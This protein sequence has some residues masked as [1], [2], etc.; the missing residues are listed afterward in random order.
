MLA[1]VTM[2]MCAAQPLLAGELPPLPADPQIAA[3]LKEISPARIR[4]DIDKL[5]SF[6]TRSTLS[7]QDPAAIAAGRGIGA[8]REWLKSQFELYA[9]ACHGCLEV[10]TD[11][12]TQMPEGR[13]P[14]PTVITNVYAV[15]KGTDPLGAAHRPG[16][17]P[18]RFARHRCPGCQPR[19]ARRQ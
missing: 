9:K 7:A 13:I 2:L 8:A 15:L 3:A 12:Y 6:G 19:C 16:D 14:T 10:K 4:A 18:L 11:G 1:L 17:R 5:V